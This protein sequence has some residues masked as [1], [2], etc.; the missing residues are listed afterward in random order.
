M[1]GFIATGSTDEPYVITNDG[2]WPDIDVVHLRTS[3]RLDGSI[4]D[5]RIEVVTVNALIQVNSELAAVKSG[6]VANGYTTIGA[7]PAFEVNGESHLIHLYRRSI[8]CGVGAELAERY[9]SYDSS[10][11]GN[12]NADELTPSVD[13]YRRDARFAIRD[14][15][16][17]GHSTVE[18]I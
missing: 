3:I 12:K 14:L 2:F 11:E 4:T 18:L 9:R 6:H 7:V 10:V 5:A 8:Y 17:V 15:L 1:S 13:E 16:G